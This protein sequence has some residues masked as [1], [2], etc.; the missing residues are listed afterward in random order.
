MPSAPA[1]PFDAL[2]VALPSLRRRGAPL[3]PWNATAFLRWLCSEGLSHGELLA[4]R[5]VLGVWNPDT[6]WVAEA[7]GEGLP[8]P[9]AAKRFDV[10]EAATTWDAPHLEALAAWLRS[11]N[12]FP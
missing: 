12:R 10:L 4:G 7:R 9:E 1:T 2:L 6:D 5:L 8:A 11:S 3:S